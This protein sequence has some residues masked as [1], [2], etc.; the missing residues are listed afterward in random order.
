MV[1]Q[2]PALTGE[3]KVKA[4]LQGVEQMKKF[5]STSRSKIPSGRELYG[6]ANRSEMIKGWYEPREVIEK[7]CG[8]ENRRLFR[9]FAHTRSRN[10]KMGDNTAF[11]L[12][13]FQQYLSLRH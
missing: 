3:Q 1:R 4:H 7:Y 6:L 12:K 13:A 8:R 2:F 11:P 10:P 5:V 9:A